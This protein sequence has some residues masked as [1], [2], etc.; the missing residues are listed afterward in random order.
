MKQ[1]ETLK[2]IQKAFQNLNE[3]TQADYLKLAQHFYKRVEGPPTPKRLR[4]ALKLAAAE[5]RPAY[6]RRLRNAIMYDQAR[7]NWSE[8]A[9]AV[10]KVNNPITNPLTE[11]EVR[12]AEIHKKKP[13]AARAKGI[14]QTDLTTLMRAILSKI[15]RASCRERV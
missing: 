4:N 13:K 8:S 12:F 7:Q 14:S 11:V 15:G 3:K 6:W 2:E 10:A 5:Y 1:P 9:L